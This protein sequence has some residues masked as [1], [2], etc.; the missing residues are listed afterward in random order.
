[1]P[2]GFDRFKTKTST[3]AF[4]SSRNN[5]VKAKTQEGFQSPRIEKAEQ[6]AE[7]ARKKAQQSF[8]LP[9]L[10]EGI[11]ETAKTIG[12]GVARS[13]V[14]TGS[15]IEQVEKELRSG[16][17]RGFLTKVSDGV[18]NAGFTPRSNFEKALTGTDKEVN[19][20]SVGRDT[21]SIFG[22]KFANNLSSGS[23]MGVGLLIA[24]LSETFW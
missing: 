4:K 2:Q 5:L 10:A 24:G 9:G 6:E 8:L 20:E 21:A 7:R 16:D 13:F 12:Q 1:M 14:A 11:K 3:P 18:K 15:T 17:D 23:A 19:F 22:D